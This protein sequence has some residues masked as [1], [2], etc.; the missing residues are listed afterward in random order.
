[1]LKKLYRGV[2]KLND[3]TNGGRIIPIGDKKKIAAQFGDSELKFDGKFRFGETTSNTARAHQLE[4]GRHGGCCV[5]TTRDKS[6]AEYFATTGNMEDGWVYVLDEEKIKDLGIA[7]FE[8]DD[9]EFPHEQEVTLLAVDAEP[10][11]EQ[12]IADKYEVKHT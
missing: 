10:I 8:F 5:S 9:P 1:M 12:V 7:M 2:S 11:P 3:E 6:R 4:T